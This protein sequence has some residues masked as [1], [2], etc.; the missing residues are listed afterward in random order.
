ML[1]TFIETGK[2][3]KIGSAENQIAKVQVVGTTNNEDALRDNFR[4]RF[5]PFYIPPLH[6]RRQDILYY[7][8]AKSPDLINKLNSSEVLTL[9]AY[10]WPGNVREIDRV[11]S[12]MLRSKVV[13]GKPYFKIKTET[14]LND[15]QLNLHDTHYT[16]INGMQPGSLF[17]LGFKLGWGQVSY[18]LLKKTW[19]GFVKSHSRI[20]H[21]IT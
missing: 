9:L 1:L 17:R 15:S 7:I 14:K 13:S 5:I 12:L 18:S 10:H 2:Y 20:I 11:A 19:F 6:E 3:R 21:L 16:F 4:F 8:S